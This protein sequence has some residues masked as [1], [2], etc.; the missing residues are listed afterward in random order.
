MKCGCRRR[1]VKI[2]QL[3]E[4]EMTGG[5]RGLI[6]FA[7]SNVNR[8]GL[9]SVRSANEC[10]VGRIWL[11]RGKM[12]LMRCWGWAA[13]LLLLQR[14]NETPISRS[15]TVESVFFFFPFLYFPSVQRPA[16]P[17]KYK[18][19]NQSAREWNAEKKREDKLIT[20]LT[21]PASKHTFAKCVLHI[22]TVISQQPPL[23][24]FV[25]VHIS[26]STCV[27]FLYVHYFLATFL[28]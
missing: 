15:W 22:S 10:L 20:Q 27:F 7:C 6:S 19:V 21:P 12:F 25:W 9:I 4:S 26:M 24:P 11:A 17:L 1:T 8:I 18:A 16:S 14:K 13:P 28:Y 2:D 23:P 5:F 3:T